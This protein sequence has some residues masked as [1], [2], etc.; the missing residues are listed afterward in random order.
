MLKRVWF[1]SFPIVTQPTRKGDQEIT[2]N[3]SA[4]EEGGLRSPH[5]F[6]VTADRGHDARTVSK[7]LTR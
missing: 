4:V 5:T 6:S 3:R 2:L 1:P 7:P